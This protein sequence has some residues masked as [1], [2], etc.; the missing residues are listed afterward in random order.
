LPFDKRKLALS[1]KHY[2]AKP[3]AVVFHNIEINFDSTIE[4]NATHLVAI[5]AILTAVSTNKIVFCSG[6]LSV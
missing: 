3:Q 5:M 1:K 2:D 6:S 4:L